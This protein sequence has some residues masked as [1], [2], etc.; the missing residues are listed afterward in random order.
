L[1]GVVDI[2]TT[3]DALLAEQVDQCL[4][5]G[6]HPPLGAW[7]EE[8]LIRS[9]LELHNQVGLKAA[10]AL[11][12]PESTIRRKVA[13]FPEL[14]LDN[15]PRRNSGWESVIALLPELIMSVQEK[16]WDPIDYARDILL[17][18]IDLQSQNQSEA[19]ALAGVSPPTYRK[20]LEQQKLRRPSL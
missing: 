18:Q 13:R 1:T 15:G 19:S 16:S 6:I 3:L 8:D 2:E 12:I 20:L 17:G 5:E 14:G 7:L 9:S 4:R 10:E 11:G